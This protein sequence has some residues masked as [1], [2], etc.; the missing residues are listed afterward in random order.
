[1]KDVGDR[2]W[3]RSAVM[4]VNDMP[5]DSSLQ[6]KVS[7]RPCFVSARTVLPGNGG[8]KTLTVDIRLSTRSRGTGVPSED[9]TQL[10]S[11]LKALQPRV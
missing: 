11:G 8:N 2:Y 5:V 4:H 3:L 10:P 9:H 7:Y 1:M 6:T